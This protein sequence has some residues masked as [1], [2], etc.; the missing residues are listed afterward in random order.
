VRGE[1]QNVFN[2]TRLPNP[3]TTG[4]QSAPTVQTSGA[5]AGLYNGGFGAVVPLSGTANSR[6]GTLIARLTF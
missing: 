5:Y 3:V 1:F 6:T 4:F 2:R